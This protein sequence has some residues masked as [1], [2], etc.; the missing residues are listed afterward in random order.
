MIGSMTRAL[1]VW[2]VKRAPISWRRGSSSMIPSTASAMAWAKLMTRSGIRVLES[3]LRLRGRA[4]Q[5]RGGRLLDLV[6]H[7][8]VDR[9]D[10]V[11]SDRAGPLAL[12]G[13]EQ[14]GVALRVPGAHLL[15][16]S[17]EVP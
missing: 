8:A 5:G 16:G 12:A 3:R 7:L 1:F 2:P 9:D 11:S 10:R 4:R 13:P 15:D 6:A 17:I 14:D